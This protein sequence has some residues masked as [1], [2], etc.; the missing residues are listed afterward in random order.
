MSVSGKKRMFNSYPNHIANKR[1]VFHSKYQELQEDTNGCNQR[2]CLGL[3]SVLL[4]G[5]C[6][7]FLCKRMYVHPCEIQRVG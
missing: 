3:I 4:L 1:T 5:A 6:L 2:K 7:V